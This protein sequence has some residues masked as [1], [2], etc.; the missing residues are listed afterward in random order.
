MQ[1]IAFNNF[2]RE[3]ELYEQEYQQAVKRVFESGWYILG[4][5][6]Q[7]FE[8]E[9][10]RYLGVKFAVGVASGTDALTI[11]IKALGLK[12]G[13]EVIIPANVYPT[14]FGV[15]LAGVKIILCDVDESTLNIDLESVK[16][17]ISNKTKAI[18]VVHLYGNPVDL[19]P[20][21]KF[22]KESGIVVI[23]DCAQA[24]G[25]RYKNK[26]V[27]S[28]GDIACF[29]FY[30]T[31]NLG[32]FG[33]GGM[34]VTDSE[35]LAKK[36]RLLRM[37]GEEGRYKSVLIGHNSRLD[38]VQAA[39]L[40]VKL[41]YLDDWNKRRREIAGIYQEKLANLSGVKF[42][43]EVRNGESCYHLMVVLVKKREKLMEYLSEKGIGVAL[44]YP[45]NI[46]NEPAFLNLNKSDSDFPV[47]AELVSR[48]LSLP[49]YPQLRDEEIMY[50]CEQIKTFYS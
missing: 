41:K 49:L 39:L 37:Y 30:P 1:K 22:S 5:E 20:L 8:E 35:E 34:V 32:A 6:V 50:I 48:I 19:E 4:N 18:V 14:V 45:I 33:D 12:D 25:A 29:S 40:L 38:E 16:K 26:M 24:A 15:S 43:G 17:V 10:A 27:G 21:T 3:Y 46:Y 42:L 23:E 2:T 47:A 13:D 36:I 11:A 9:F 7:K 44:H 28:F 31:K